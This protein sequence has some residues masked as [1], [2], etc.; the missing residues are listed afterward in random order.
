MRYDARMLLFFLIHSWI[1][2]CQAVYEDEA[3]HDDYHHAL[4]GSPQEH[5]TFFHR[6]SAASK[7]SLLYTLSAQNIVGAVNP[8]DG[9]IV[10]RQRL[11]ESGSKNNKTGYLI[12]I[13]NESIVISGYGGYLR[14]WNA[15]D[16]RLVWQWRFA[17]DIRGL[18]AW[19][20]PGDDNGVLV[21]SHEEGK[22]VVRRLDTAKGE[23]KWSYVDDR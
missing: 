19:V 18:E 11:D 6:P 1:S 22:N 15:A 8:K 20:K 3:Y 17:G 23:T 2:I 10:W 16:G 21:L 12:A 13:E 9:G 7:A 14:A 4:L 5:T